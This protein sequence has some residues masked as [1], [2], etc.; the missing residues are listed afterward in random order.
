M[1]KTTYKWSTCKAKGALFKHCNAQILCLYLL[2]CLTVTQYYLKLGFIIFFD[3][4]D[5]FL[6]IAKKKLQL[7]KKKNRGELH[8]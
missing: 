6:A 8:S 3:Y 2:V 5:Y 1:P 4:F 7:Q